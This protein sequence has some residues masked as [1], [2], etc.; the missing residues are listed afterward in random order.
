[1]HSVSAIARRPGPERLLLEFHLLFGPGRL[2]VPP[3][4]R[5]RRV[6]RLWEHSCGEVFV[7]RPGAGYLEF[8][9]S[10]SG[11]WAAWSFTGYRQDMTEA[12]T[13][14]PRITTRSRR[15]HL[16]I[17]VELALPALG[18]TPAWELALAAVLEDDDGR[19]SYWALAHPERRPDFHHPGS[20][21]CRLPEDLHS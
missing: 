14:P 20:F 19:R 7:R 15:G 4:A 8:N 1:M 13:P 21:A 3:R 10:P 12:D 16:R 2:R 9:L 5:P 6:A 18:A 11:E 17:A